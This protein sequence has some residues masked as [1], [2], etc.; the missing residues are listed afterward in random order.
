[1]NVVL[2]PLLASGP[3]ATYHS[4]CPP[5]SYVN[6]DMTTNAVLHVEVVACAVLGR[7]PPEPHERARSAPTALRATPGTDADAPAKL[8]ATFGMGV[9]LRSIAS[10]RSVGQRRVRHLIDIRQ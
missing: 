8:V 5:A 6:I 4:E 1:M 3:A 10:C 7:V 2:E 9:P